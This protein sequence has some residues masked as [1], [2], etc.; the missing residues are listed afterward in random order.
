MDRYAA[1][2]ATRLTQTTVGSV[3]VAMRSFATAVF[4][5]VA[6]ARIRFAATAN[7]RA[8]VVRSPFVSHALW[9]AAIV[10]SNSAQTV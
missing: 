7:I 1:T 4:I 8:T 10:K 3:A 6:T 2:A 9:L 5:G